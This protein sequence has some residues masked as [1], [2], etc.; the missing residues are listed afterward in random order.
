[1][2]PVTRA[3][4]EDLLFLEADLLD[5]WKLDEWLAQLSEDIGAAHAA[6]T[7]A[8]PVAPFAVNL[9]VHASNNRLAEDLLGCRIGGR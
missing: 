9:I 6:S 8:D 1:M 7:P 2:S 3:E 5:Q 4:A